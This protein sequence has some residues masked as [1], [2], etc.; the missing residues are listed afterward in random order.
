MLLSFEHSNGD[1]YENEYFAVTLKNKVAI[2]KI[3][4]VLSF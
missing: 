4:K 2:L 3:I 1:L